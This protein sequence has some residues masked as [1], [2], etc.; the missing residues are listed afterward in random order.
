M[1]VDK[2]LRNKEEFIFSQFWSL[3]IQGQGVNSIGAF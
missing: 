3:K 2:N 1:L